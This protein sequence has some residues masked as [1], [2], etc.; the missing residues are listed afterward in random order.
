MPKRQSPTEGGS[1]NSRME[2][3]L[4][5]GD[6]LRRSVIAATAIAAPSRAAN[7]NPYQYRER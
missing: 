2:S 6:F 7:Q 3:I 1:D 5:R 4:T